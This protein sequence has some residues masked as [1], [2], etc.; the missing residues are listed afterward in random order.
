MEQKH[1]SKRMKIKGTAVSKDFYSPSIKVTDQSLM[2]D[3]IIADNLSKD[4]SF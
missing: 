1:L 3:K 4:L 2:R